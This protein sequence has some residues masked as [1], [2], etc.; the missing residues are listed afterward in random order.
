MSDDYQPEA[1][2]AKS[3]KGLMVALL[4]ILLVAAAIIAVMYLVGIG[5]FATDDAEPVAETTQPATESEEDPEEETT[6]P[7]A[8]EA[9]VPL[10]PAEA[11]ESMY[12]EQ[13]A[14]AST[15]TDLVDD[16]FATFELSQLAESSD[17][18]NVRVKA[19]YRDGT[20]MNGWIVLKKYEGAWYFASITADGHTVTT[21]VLGTADADIVKAIVEQQAQNQDIYIAILDGTYNAITIDKVGGGSGTATV[22]ITLSGATAPDSSAKITCISKSAGG[23]T[24]WFITAFSE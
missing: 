6:T 1:D 12:W 9:N 15:I 16:K 18:A 20:T 8:S 21:P 13:V 23:T 17:L 4:G 19:T 24:Q 22:D 10:P 3:R 7:V 11:Q 5:P 2:V 14:S